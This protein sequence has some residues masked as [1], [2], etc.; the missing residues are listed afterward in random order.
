MRSFQE[1]FLLEETSDSIPPV[2]CGVPTEITIQVQSSVKS[3]NDNKKVSLL[4]D[5]SMNIG[6]SLSKIPIAKKLFISLISTIVN[7]MPELM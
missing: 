4:T 5:P 7:I 1:S 6:F 3:L 2:A